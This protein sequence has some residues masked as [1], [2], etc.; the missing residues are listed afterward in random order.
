MDFGVLN[1]TEYDAADPQDDVWAAVREMAELVDESGFDSLWFGEHHV[2]PDHQYMQN[3]TALAATAAITSDVT[4]GAGALLLPLHN[5]VHIAELG[6][7]IDVVSDG[8]LMLTCGLGYR[9][10]EFEAF[11]VDKRDRVGRLEEGIEVIRRLWTEDEVSY[12]GEHVSLDGVTINPKPIA[13]PH[14]PLMVAG[15]ADAAAKRAARIGDSWYY[16]NVQSRAELERQLEVYREAVADAGRTEETFAPPIMRE[17]FVLPDE[18][19]A[20]ETV[21]PYLVDKY[22]TYEGWGL[23]DVDIAGNFREASEGRFLI[24]SPQTVL[25]ELEAYHEAGVEHVVARIQFP[26][27]APADAKRSLETIADEVLP[28]LPG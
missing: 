17:A 9:D 16:G 7:S 11:G 1:L 22:S 5:P 20:V 10:A 13:S 8:R 28:H 15:Y 21:E 27:M 6:A 19:E 12:D 25:A 3:T 14:P 23:G 4:L 18:D 2:T 24:G 26:G